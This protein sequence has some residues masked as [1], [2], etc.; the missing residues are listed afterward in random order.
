MICDACH[1]NGYVDNPQY[2]RYGNVVAYERGIS[3]TIRCKRCGGAG[4]FVG[5]VNEAIMLLKDAIHERRGL[6]TKETKQLLRI[7]NDYKNGT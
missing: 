1:G 5:N 2:D 4:F 6:T 3:R 7:L